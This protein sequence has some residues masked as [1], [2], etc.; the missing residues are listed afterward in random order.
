[1]RAIIISRK[2]CEKKG[3]FA[4][5]LTCKVVEAEFRVGTLVVVPL[6]AGCKKHVAHAH[7]HRQIY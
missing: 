4:E 3:K 6:G 1:M 5:N 2:G 7:E